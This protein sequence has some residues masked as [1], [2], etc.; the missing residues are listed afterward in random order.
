[1]SIFGVCLEKASN[2]LIFQNDVKTSEEN[3]K[4]LLFLSK[5]EP[6]Q[7]RLDALNFLTLLSDYAKL[8]VLNKNVCEDYCELVLLYLECIFEFIIGRPEKCRAFAKMGGSKRLKSLPK[9]LLK[10]VEIAKKLE[11]ILTEL[12]NQG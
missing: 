5:Y 2:I 8:L 4:F 11:L 7:E 1:M 9:I 12:A 6:Y 10:N 3:L